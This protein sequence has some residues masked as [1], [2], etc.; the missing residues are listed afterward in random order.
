MESFT[1][2]IEEYRDVLFIFL[3]FFIFLYVIKFV[4]K[5]SKAL[6]S[7]WREYKI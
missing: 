1:T 6:F 7:A 3:G 2:F 5:I 4:I